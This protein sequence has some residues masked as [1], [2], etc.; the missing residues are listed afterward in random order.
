MNSSETELSKTPDKRRSILLRLLGPGLVTGP[1]TTIRLASRLIPSRSAIWSW[2]AVDGFSGR[3]AALSIGLAFPDAHSDLKPISL[4]QRF[5][6]QVGANCS[7]VH[8]RFVGH[9]SR[10]SF[11]NLAHSHRAEHN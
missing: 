6:N 8:S 3:S 11:D 2:P 4:D 5:L 10:R 9:R 1:R 7:F